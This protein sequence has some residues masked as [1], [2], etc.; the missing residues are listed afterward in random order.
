MMPGFKYIDRF[1]TTIKSY[2]KSIISLL[3]IIK[4]AVE[5]N[6]DGRT[7]LTTKIVD[8]LVNNTE[9]ID[10]LEKYF[11]NQNVIDIRSI[12]EL[13][14]INKQ[15]GEFMQNQRELAEAMTSF[16]K[17]ELEAA[18]KMVAAEKNLE[19]TKHDLRF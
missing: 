16:F 14:K 12:E 1:L 11:K 15:L 18:Q 13:E 4:K 9:K 6:T 8:E 2:A 10:S 19:P 17:A 5:E 3:E 7:T